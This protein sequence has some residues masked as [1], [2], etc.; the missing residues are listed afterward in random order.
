MELWANL[1]GILDTIYG[2]KRS[3]LSNTDTF[4]TDLFYPYMVS[5]VP[6]H[7]TLILFTQIYFTHIWY[8]AFLSI[9]H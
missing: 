8:Q 9:E 5:S 6:I 3:Y 1:I 4:H 2:T 7:R